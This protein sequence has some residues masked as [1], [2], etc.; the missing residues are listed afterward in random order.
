MAEPA[1]R[2]HIDMRKWPD[3]EHSQIEA[4]RLG[5]DEYGTWIYAK[6]GTLLTRGQESLNLEFGFVG[7]A[8]DDEWWVVEFWLGHPE[9]DLYVNIGTP[10]VWNGSRLTQIDLDLDV[11]RRL[12]GRV[13][14][15][16]ID[17]FEEHQVEYGYPE[18]LV[19]GAREAADR[20]VEMIQDS[21]EPFA[22]VFERWVAKVDP[23]NMRRR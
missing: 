16:D 22:S 9:V 7:L 17:E 21:A 19:V 13:E 2:I 6:P 11:I 12:D 8:P 18:E 15:I 20:A 5:G 1:N 4:S 10:P 3:R 23:A 14:V